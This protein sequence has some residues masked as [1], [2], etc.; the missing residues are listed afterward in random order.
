MPLHSN[1]GILLDAS[2]L[3]SS[4]PDE[5]VVD[6]GSNIGQSQWIGAH[7]WYHQ[8]P[9]GMMATYL[10]PCREHLVVEEKFPQCRGDDLLQVEG[11]ADW[12]RWEGSVEVVA[13]KELPTTLLT[14][15]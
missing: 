11:A 15:Q 3:V 8:A 2:M 9:G 7:T 13:I 6:L 14:Y 4:V 5:D 12:F 1:G 10:E